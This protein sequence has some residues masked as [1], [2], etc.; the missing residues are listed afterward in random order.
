VD[1]TTSPEEQDDSPTLP[2]RY[3]GE[4]VRVN[5]KK[6]RFCGEWLDESMRDVVRGR[7]Q[8]RA[9]DAPVVLKIWGALTMGFSGLL[10]VLQVVQAIYMLFAFGGRFGPGVLM[11][12]GVATAVTLLVFGIFG[13]LG[14][15]LW[16]GQRIAVIGYGLFGALLFLLIGALS[17]M[18]G[19]NTTEQVVFLTVSALIF[20]PPVVVGVVS[21]KRLS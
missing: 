21:W 6:C 12:T 8:P 3:C 16:C 5:A 20:L 10:G 18:G 15:G 14:W 19:G 7:G 9:F 2:C 1:E 11:G 13:R 4:P 17:N